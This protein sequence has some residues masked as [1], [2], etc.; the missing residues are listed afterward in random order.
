MERPLPRRRT[1]LSREKGPC[2]LGS[3]SL[4]HRVRCPC[5]LPPSARDQHCSSFP[6]WVF[7]NTTTAF[8]MTLDT[9]F[10][11][12]MT[13]MITKT[14]WNSCLTTTIKSGARS[15]HS[16]NNP[17]AIDRKAH[18]LA[19]WNV[20]IYPGEWVRPKHTQNLRTVMHTMFT[21]SNI[22]TVQI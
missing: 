9:I 20:P 7:L 12:Q 4:A 16:W 22:M 19:P 3:G 17:N 18:E 8:P 15:M 13:M 10:A 1:P 14:S 21:H 11:G 6:F 5:T 2:T